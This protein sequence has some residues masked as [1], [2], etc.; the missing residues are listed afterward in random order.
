M[1]IVPEC[2]EVPVQASFVEHDEGIQALA[3]KRPN[4][5]FHVSSL[6][7]CPWCRQHLFDAHRLHLL[8]EVLAEDPIAIPQQVPW[9]G[10]PGE[11]FAHLLRRPL[12]RGMCGDREVQDA[13]P[14]VCQHQKHVQDLERIVGTTKKSTE[15]SVFR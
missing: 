5:P 13:T 8:A 10:I 7:R 3:A 12:C 14:F 15:I 2:P 11:G 4:E 1:I 6:P 9:R